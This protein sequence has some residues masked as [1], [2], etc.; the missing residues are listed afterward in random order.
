MDNVPYL[1]RRRVLISQEL[2]IAFHRRY[3]LEMRRRMTALV[4][5]Y[6]ASDP[7]PLIRL[8]EEFGVTHL[9]LDASDYAEPPV[10]FK[11]YNPYIN[12]AFEHLAEGALEARTQ[13][14]RVVIFADDPVVV[15]DLSRI[16]P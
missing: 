10:Y 12:N 5:A 14:D 11:P 6:Y 1:C 13:M 15:V 16:L 7:A 2:H 9:V 8:R 4:D 3:L